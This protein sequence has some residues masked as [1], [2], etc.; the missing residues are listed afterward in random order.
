MPASR[1]E[2]AQRP[3]SGRAWIL[4]AAKEELA[5]LARGTGEIVLSE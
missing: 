4:L 1:I 5:S 3:A 2:G